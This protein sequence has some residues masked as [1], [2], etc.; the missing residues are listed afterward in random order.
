MPERPLVDNSTVREA[1]ARFSARPAQDTY[2]D[3]LRQCLTGEL[4]L[5]VTGSDFRIVD[6]ALQQGST[7]Q[8]RGGSGPKGEKALLAFTDQEQAQRIHHDDPEAVQTLG[9]PAVGVLEMAVSQGYELLYLDPA[10]PTISLTL[11]D[12]RFA[13]HGDR[14]DAVKAALATGDRAAV[15]EALAQGGILKYSAMEVEGGE[16]GEIQ[17]ATTTAPDGS[18]A[19][20]AFTSTAE[21]SARDVAAG[22]ASVPVA[23]ALAEALEE[24][25]TGLV[26]NPAGPWM[27]LP[28]DDIR[29]LL[30]R[31][32]DASA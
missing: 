24:P 21:V 9:Q 16:Q 6:G 4:L 14:N 32:G 11:E 3:V 5:D 18:P 25:F 27:F 1:I 13:L 12:I 26:L 30:A 22:A 19:R 31:L 7:I 2:L 17:V 10:G 28:H 20:L 29:A 23:Q 15:I 8:V